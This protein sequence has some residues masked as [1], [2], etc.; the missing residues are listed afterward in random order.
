VSDETEVISRAEGWQ[1]AI[2]ARDVDAAAGF[3]ADDYALVIVQ[4]SRAI[5][6]RDR[7]LALLPDYVVS[8]YEVLERIVDVAGDLASVLQRVHQEAI[9]LGADRSGIFVLSD[10]WRRRDGT[11]KV[12]RRHSTP[13]AAG[14]MPGTEDPARL[15][16]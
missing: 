8:G 10:T 1:R 16:S 14:A 3:L 12:W 11:W 9:V 2:E 15:Q 7:W 5:V 13:L 4:P 6:A